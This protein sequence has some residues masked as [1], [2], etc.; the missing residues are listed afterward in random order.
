MINRFIYSKNVEIIGSLSGLVTLPSDYKKGELLPVIVFLHGAGER[1]ATSE[2][3]EKLIMTHG[4]PKYF[5][6]NCDFHGH[7]VITL[8]PACPDNVVWDNIAYS[9][10]SWIDSAVSE[11]GGDKEKIAITG[12][13][14][15]GF[16]T[17]NMIITFPDY[18]C[19]AAP[20]CG[21]GAA[22]RARSLNK[23]SIRAFHGIDDESVPV[24]H[25]LL[26]V[27]HAKKGG[28]DVSLTTFDH[29]GH[30]SWEPAYETTDIIE[31]LA[32]GGK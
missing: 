22:W 4:I 3:L 26:M 5:G 18:F 7:R 29:C 21:G 1:G 24:E 30:N 20:I 31:W 13:S 32:N 23:I 11:F 6:N 19:C 27:E 17:W 25:S 14:M 2:N 10:K 8:S 15:G 9:L 12:I 16:G 28:A